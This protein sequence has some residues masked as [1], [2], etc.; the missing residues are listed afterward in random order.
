MVNVLKKGGG[1]GRNDDYPKELFFDDDDNNT[2]R[3]KYFVRDCQFFRGE[4]FLVRSRIGYTEAPLARTR[5]AC[6]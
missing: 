2:R 1:D 4:A 6:K 5:L 3:M